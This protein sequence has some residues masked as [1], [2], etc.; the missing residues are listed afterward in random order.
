MG[1][2]LAAQL[3]DLPR[4]LVSFEG[5]WTRSRR[6]SYV[7]P[8]QLCSGSGPYV[9][10]VD[11]RW[12]GTLD[13][14]EPVAALLLCRTADR[15][16]WVKSTPAAFGMPLSASLSGY[17][18][19]SEN[20][21]T[22]H[23]RAGGSCTPGVPIGLKSPRDHFKVPASASTGE[24]VKFLQVGAVEVAALFL[25]GSVLEV[26]RNRLWRLRERHCASIDDSARALLT[27]GRT[28]VLRPTDIDDLGAEGDVDDHGSHAG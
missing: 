11:D 26:G 7:G 14:S 16:Y 6:R 21:Y 8:D 13:A 4:A 17:A 5:G 22:A 12:S 23:L 9:E 24:V 2:S 10:V 15:I 3:A 1:I 27:R 28:G 18:G 20:L 25:P 19:Y